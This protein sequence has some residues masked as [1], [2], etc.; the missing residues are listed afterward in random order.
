MDCWVRDIFFCRNYTRQ[1]ISDYKKLLE[2]NFRYTTKG[3][4]VVELF[5]KKTNKKVVIPY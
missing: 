3:I 5:Q 1:R 2:S 4:R